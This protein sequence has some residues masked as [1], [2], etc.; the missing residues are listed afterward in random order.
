MRSWIRRSFR[1]RVFCTVLLVTLLPLLLCDVLMMQIQVLRSQDQLTE[2]AKAQLSQL[3]QALTDTCGACEDLAEDLCGNTIVRSALRSGGGDSRVLYQ[4]LF[5]STGDLRQYARFDIFNASGQCQYTTDRVLPEGTLPTD[6]GILYAAG[7][8][9]ELV[10]RDGA[11]QTLLGARAV[12]SADGDILGYVVICMGRENFDLLFHDRYAATGDVILFS[13]QWRTIYCSEQIR[14]ANAAGQLRNSLLEKGDL[15][16]DTGEYYFHA[17]RQADTGFT[18][19]LQQPRTFTTQVMR[20]IYAVS[21]LMGVL[22]LLLCLWCAWLL[23]RHLSQPVDQLD[24]AMDQVKRGDLDVRL[25]TDR[26]DELGRLTD[27]FNRMTEQYQENLTRSV[28][29]QRELNETQLRMM[30][31]QLNPH[32][33]YN[34]LDTMKWLGLSHQVPQVATLATD[35]AAILRSS[36][37]GGGFTTLEGELELVDR[38]LDIQSIRFE[39][40]FTC[41]IDVPDRLQSCLVPKLV[42][43][44]VVENAILHGV[45]DMD[46]GY[47]KLW[48]LERQGDL[49]LYV[50]DNGRGFPEEVIRAVNSGQSPG[51]GGHLGLYNVN[52]MLRLRFGQGYGIYVEPDAEEG[53]RVRLTLP[54]MREGDDRAEGFG[55]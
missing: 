38:Y 7:Q 17:L 33:L 5:R 28:Q 20:S 10:F 41:E 9:R 27:S 40:R 45:A 16:V 36:I 54:L 42:L 24:A 13:P 29:R 21:T 19:I 50:S 26:E 2:E 39:D 3:S 25:Q 43:Q 55:G 18:L 47:I 15:A 12:R 49:L 1:N 32:F 8:S 6:W 34:T 30:Q 23:S 46:D 53:S 44:P 14:A 52:S 35:L 51:E 37:S 4:L 48:A 31:A 11:D 22:C